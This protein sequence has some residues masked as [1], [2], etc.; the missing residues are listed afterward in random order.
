MK[1]ESKLFLILFIIFLIRSWVATSF[2]LGADEAHYVLYGRNLALSYFDHPPLVGWT[3]WFFTSLPL[4]GELAA[5][6]P[7]LLI[8]VLTSILIYYFLIR[9]RFSE[10]L[11]LYSVLGLNL[12]PFYNIFS[13]FFLPDTWLMPLAF[14]IFYQVEQIEK[15]PSSLNWLLLGLW[16][17]LAGLAKYTAVLFVPGLVLY[18]LIQN[19]WRLL[20][21]PQ[22]LWGIGIAA[23]L[24]S[25]V[26]IWNYQNDWQSFRY[27]GNHISGYDV[28]L[29]NVFKTQAMQLVGWGFVF[30]YL[31]IL[32]LFKKVENLRPLWKLTSICILLF[33]LMSS[34]RQVLL[35]HW[36]MIF[37]IITIP[38][39]I[40]YYQKSIFT[41]LGFLLS[42]LMTI[43]IFAEILFAVFPAQ[44][45]ALLYKDIYDWS[46]IMNKANEAA[47]EHNI[48]HIAVLNWSLGSRAMYYNPGHHKVFVLDNRTDQFDIW[49]P[50]PAAGTK[51]L[52]L[53]EIEKA[54]EQL[55]GINCTELEKLDEYS[56]L[57]KGVPIN[58]IQYFSCRI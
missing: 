31:S 16:L 10:E 55:K 45:T 21:K 2:G 42:G 38:I 22:I 18:F 33:F 52:V 9:I 46:G 3:Q 29:E 54:D 39:A 53:T 57:K 8:S 14:L 34:L 20:I 1:T 5:R 13:L 56:S 23:L 36:M 4:P 19:R 15:K 24:I 28:N 37:F 27:Q 32:I 25:P 40:A 51:V 17:G 26:F 7:A 41:K 30:Y 11:A 43:T 6:L 35:A 58:I 47:L 50:M 49:S 48:Q 12:T 44:K